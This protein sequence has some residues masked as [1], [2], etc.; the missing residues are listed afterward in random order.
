[1]ELHARA[2]FLTMPYAFCS[3]A[4]SDRDKHTQQ[5][6]GWCHKVLRIPSHNAFHDV[7]ASTRHKVCDHIGRF[8]S[9]RLHIRLKERRVT[10]RIEA[11]AP[12]RFRRRTARAGAVRLP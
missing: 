7:K 8:A 4:W 2:P 1:M 3:S 5:A 11:S 6:G 9:E 10:G 12:S